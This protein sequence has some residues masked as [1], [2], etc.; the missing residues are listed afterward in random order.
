VATVKFPV[1]ALRGED[2]RTLR[3]LGLGD[4]YFAQEL[5]R[6]ILMKGAIEMR[7]L[8]LDEMARL[9]QIIGDPD[10]ASKTLSEHVGAAL[11]L[12]FTHCKDVCAKW[13]ES[14][15]GLEDGE[16]LKSEVFPLGALPRLAEGIANHPDLADFLAEG[17]TLLTPEKLLP[18]LGKIKNATEAASS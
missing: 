4:L 10:T 14:L 12:G 6:E 13:I 16:A 17:R 7:A 11:F 3:G 9:A 1:V 15:L 8:G 5:I 18:I 2:K